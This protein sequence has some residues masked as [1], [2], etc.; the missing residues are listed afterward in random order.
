MT[1]LAIAA[2]GSVLLTYGSL[3]RLRRVNPDGQIE[4]LAGAGFSTADEIP[5]VDAQFEGNLLD[6]AIGPDGSIFVA[7]GLP[8]VEEQTY[9][10]KIRVR[11]IST[12]GIITTV[13]GS[14]V[15]GDSGDGG[16]AT[17]AQFMRIAGVGVGRDG[18]LYIADYEAGRVRRVGADGIITTVAG[19]GASLEDGTRRRTPPS[20]APTM[21][22]STATAA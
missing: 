8:E 7:E 4:T 22:L 9:Q 10:E 5:A 20:A 6:V 3:Q 19:G 11:R 13:A 12:D 14:G 2:D 21:S 16:L 1:G 15:Y 17:S 18:T